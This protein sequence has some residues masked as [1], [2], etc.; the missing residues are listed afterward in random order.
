M[1][2]TKTETSKD[3]N[4]RSKSP[5][6]TTPANKRVP[7]PG[8]PEAAQPA[9]ASGSRSVLAPA[10]L[11]VALVAAG[12]SGALWLQ[13]RQA[14]QVQA[15]VG[16]QSAASESAANRAAAQA[17]EALERLEAQERRIESLQARLGEASDVIRDLDEALR[18]MTDRGSE[19]VLLN[20]IDHL[21]TIAQQQ[22]QLGGNVRNAIVALESA[23][24]QL[25]RAN[26]PAL[27][28]L[29]QTVNGDLDRLRAASTVDVAAFSR[30]LEELAMLLTEAPLIMPDEAGRQ[31]ERP[32]QPALREQ[33]APTVPPSSS[34]DERWWERAW[35]TTRDWSQDAWT[36]VR[37]DLGQFID[38]RRVDDANAL[39]MSP[40]QAA[41]FRENL[42]TRVMTAQ[43]AL[44]M[45]Q[46]EVWRTEMEV[47][48]RAV[49][50]RYD[51]ASPLTRKALRLARGMADASIDARLPTV[52]NTLQALNT[53]REAQAGSLGAGTPEPAAEAPMNDSP[54]PADTDA[55]EGNAAEPA[56]E[57]PV[58]EPPEPASGSNGNA[59]S[60]AGQSDT[61]GLDNGSMPAQGSEPVTAGRTEG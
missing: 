11:V 51:E 20:D 53:L 30:E 43:L 49:E 6:L 1:T 37:E 34:A 57:P 29:L 55:P 5:V 38:V 22:L 21:A 48:V 44:M 42:R 9:A 33:P 31:A 23:Q 2:D 25:A 61:G 8:A 7:P 3:E 35:E 52:D 28:S 46:P 60:P 36:S 16:A 50:T 39:L 15:A 27:A 41:R 45:R 13:H 32:E 54:E 40:D 47:I 14:V 18:T 24:A 17:S 10:A 59:E 26:R 12:L 56:P 4:A 19:L 58:G